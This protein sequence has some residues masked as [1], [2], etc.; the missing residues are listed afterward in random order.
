[1]EVDQPQGN[2]VEVEKHPDTEDQPDL[3]QWNNLDPAFR[4][5]AAVPVAQHSLQQVF[6]SAPVA[7]GQTPGQDGKKKGAQGPRLR[8]ACD[9]CSKRKVKVSSTSYPKLEAST[10]NKIRSQCDETARPCR[11]CASLDIPC[12]Y[13]RPSRRRGP[14]NRHADA[15][16]A[17]QI[18]SSP[19]GF[20]NSGPS[21]PTHAAQTLASL[22]QQQALSQQ[23]DISPQHVVSVDDICPWELLTALVDD[24]FTYIHPLVPVPHE[25]SF[26]NALRTAAAMSN[27]IMVALTASMVGFLT[28]SFPRQPMHHIGHFGLGNLFPNHETLIARCHKITLQALGLG[29]LDTGLSIDH[30][31]ISY[32]QAMTAAYLFQ[33]G[34][35]KLYLGQC[36]NMVRVVGC[37]RKET[38]GSKPSPEGGPKDLILQE[39]NRRMFWI[40]FTTVKSFQQLGLS[41]RELNILPPTNA[42]P[43]PELPK[44][45]DDYCITQEAI[46]PM[47]P[48]LVS[49]MTAFNTTV[50]VYLTYSE[51]CRMEIAYGIN[52]LYYDWN[53]QKGTVKAALTA[54]KQALNGLPPDL[55]LTSQS[56]VY[57]PPTHGGYPH[58][59]DL[60]QENHA[61]NNRQK[62]IQFEVQKANLYASQLGT[63]SYLME[64]YDN[65]CDAYETSSIGR[66][67]MSTAGTNTPG[68]PI[69]IHPTQDVCMNKGEMNSER[70]SI[71]DDLLGLIQR[72]DPVYMEPS[73]MSFVNHPTFPYLPFIFFLHQ[74]LKNLVPPFLLPN[75]PFYPSLI[76]DR[77]PA[78]QQDPPDREHLAQLAREPAVKA[79]PPLAGEHDES[80]GLHVAYSALGAGEGGRGGR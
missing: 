50:G 14:R 56:S 4:D 7:N 57:P 15:I 64:K 42:E 12:T 76:Y 22:S 43:Y 29:Y 60:S 23:Q 78:G 11:A 28:A 66:A 46:N 3:R 52:E 80:G 74:P 26:R 8:K 34:V 35:C 13:E 72:L 79:A 30:A 73:G 63:R 37:D 24:Y 17:G 67:A 40:V 75:C 5:N 59:D 51:V 71:V 48:G 6:S 32:L 53:H 62:K 33:W 61:Y 44:E 21:S 65:L 25:P 10:S 19:Q 20:T 27:P 18:H 41:G 68:Q 49:E 45:V 54:V 31:I 69:V 2:P 38:P 39:L 77:R 9:S 36:M 58:M 55:Y 70:E 1:M 47:P 16:R